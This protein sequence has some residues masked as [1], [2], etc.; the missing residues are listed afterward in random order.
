MTSTTDRNYPE[1]IEHTY[2]FVVSTG[3]KAERLDA[4]IT[5]SIV[6][7]TR[8]RVQK[9]IDR[10]S[11]TVN[12]RVEKSNYKVRPG[13]TV[14]VVVMKPPPLQLVPEEIPLEVLYEDEHLIVV[15]KPAGMIVHPGIGNRYGTLVNAIL[16]HVGMRDPIDVL[17]NRESMADDDFDD[18]S[19]DVESSMSSSEQ[20]RAED[21]LADDDD[22]LQ[23]NALRPG[24]VHRLDKD[25]SGVMVVGKTYDATLHLSNQFAARTVS[26]EYVALAW[27]VI[28]QDVQLIETQ[29]GRSTRDRKLHSVLSHGGK[30]AAT[31]VHVIERYE[32]TTLI[33]CRLRTG[34]THQIRVHLA[35]V[36]H[37]L[38]GDKDYGG[39]EPALNGVHHQFRRRA[40]TALAMIHRQ[41]LHARSLE[42][43]H[44]VTN[45]R[46]LFTS[47]VPADFS[48]V[49]GQLRPPEAGPLPSC[50][51]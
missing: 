18:E 27:G 31:E 24:I 42:F 13:D 50:L 2:E 40:Q 39:R 16:W 8:T 3:K 30:Y 49:V 33:T 6:H 28:Q 5:R 14:T 21:E 43:T 51:L 41:A 26:R 48:S 23:S 44:P 22:A 12:G 17:G 46:M 15:N 20:D 11:V 7:A 47:A 10:G 35:H 36:K 32:S 34:R 1:R 25:T 19:E 9:A 29:F 38:V 4:F 37:P 45:K